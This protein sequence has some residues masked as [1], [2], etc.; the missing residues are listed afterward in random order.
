MLCCQ[1]ILGIHIG[2]D[3]NLT[4]SLVLASFYSSV[5]FLGS[6]YLK[7]GAC[8]ISCLMP[9]NALVYSGIFMQMKSQTF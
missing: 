4:S 7:T 9:V 3:K 5:G 2:A 1:S 8:M 6:E